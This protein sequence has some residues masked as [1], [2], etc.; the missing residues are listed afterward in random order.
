MPAILEALANDPS[1][2]EYLQ[3]IRTKMVASDKA[4]EHARIVRSL[5]L[6]RAIGEAGVRIIEIAQEQ[7][8]DINSAMADVEAVVRNVRK[9]AP[10]ADLSPKPADIIKR[11]EE[12]RA[13]NVIPVTFLPKLQEWTGGMEAGQIWVVGGFSSV[14]KSAIGVNF[15]LDAFKQG[16]RVGLVSLE[17]TDE[18]YMTRFLSIV[19][20]VGQRVIRRREVMTLA[21]A[22]AL[23]KAK[24]FMSEAPLEIYS[25]GRELKKIV[26]TARRMKETDGLDLLIVDFLQNVAVGSF[27]EFA[28]A[29]EA[30][31][32]FQQVAKDL[33]CTVLAFSQISNE[34]A[35]AQKANDG[36]K[37]GYYSF[38]GHGAIRDAADVGIML[39]RDQ[40]TNSPILNVDVVKNRHDEKG[41][42]RAN[43]ELK[44]GRIT[45]LPDDYVEQ[46]DTMTIGEA[47]DIV[48]SLPNAGRKKVWTK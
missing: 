39:E 16:K 22:D 42:I 32:E 21:E 24:Q 35:K 37:S 12:N 34:S 48:A 26:S 13:M 28:S 17:M 46:E 8:T 20:G 36:K 5:A 18:A 31:L 29:R 41:L 7:R 19:S 6:M 23:K 1:A 9:T 27:D 4:V 33:R 25:P 43:M 30:S 38:K 44:T 45:Q 10:P 40:V 2:L 3:S 11:M 14:G 47:V 15:A